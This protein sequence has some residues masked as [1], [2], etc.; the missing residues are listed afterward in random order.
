MSVTIQSLKEIRSWTSWCKQYFM[1]FSLNHWDEILFPWTKV[2]SSLCPPWTIAESHQDL[3]HTQCF[4]QHTKSY[5]DWLGILQQKNCRS[6][7]LV[8]I[9]AL[10]EGKGLYKWHQTMDSN[11]AYHNSKFER[12][13]FIRTK[14]QPTLET[15]KKQNLIREGLPWIVTVQ[16]KT[17]R[18]IKKPICCTSTLSFIKINWE[19]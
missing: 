13:W 2:M 12:S 19:L 1:I 14:H 10:N 6:S 9:M 11:C 18:N 3:H 8:I 15:L 17:G 4:Q 16:N 5:L 7:V